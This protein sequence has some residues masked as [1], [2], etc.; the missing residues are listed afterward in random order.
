[1]SDAAHERVIGKLLAHIEK[2]GSDERLRELAAG[3]REGHAGW[4]ESLRAPAYAE[5]LQ[6]GLNTFT[7]WYGQLSASERAEQAER[8]QRKLDE[9]AR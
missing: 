9:P 1:M 7:G 2:N 8:Y 6:P 3:L 4:A 5:A